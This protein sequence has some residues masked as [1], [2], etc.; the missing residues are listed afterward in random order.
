LSIDCLLYLEVGLL[1]PFVPEEI[2]RIWF[3]IRQA[4]FERRDYI[5]DLCTR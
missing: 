2:D 3:F 4:L 1:E 5:C